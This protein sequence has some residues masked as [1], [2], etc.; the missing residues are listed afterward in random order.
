[1]NLLWTQKN[2]IPIPVYVPF[3]LHFTQIFFRK[4]YRYTVSI[5]ID[6]PGKSIDRKQKKPEYKSFKP[7]G[8]RY[9][10][11]HFR[12][13]LDDVIVKVFDHCRKYQINSVMMHIRTWKM[14]PSKVI[15]HDIKYSLA[16]S[17]IV[18]KH[19]NVLFCTLPIIGQ[20]TAINELAVK[21]V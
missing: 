21:K 8:R 5:S 15:V 7:R 2:D 11:K 17:A 19:D 18:V 6:D 1:M 12:D 10:G 14:F 20:N 13:L 9:V 4:V 16:A 3:L